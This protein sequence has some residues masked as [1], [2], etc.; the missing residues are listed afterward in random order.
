MSIS[1][2]QLAAVLSLIGMI[3][4]GV[5]AIDK[6]YT[7]REITDI[8]VADLQ[9]NQMQIQQNIQVQTALNWLQ[10]WQIQVS[11]LTGLCAVEPWNAQRKQQLLNAKRERDKWQNEVNRLMNK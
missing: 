4:G 5:W 3:V 9:K 8:H 6:R 7:P 11:Q 2:K 10:Y 1:I